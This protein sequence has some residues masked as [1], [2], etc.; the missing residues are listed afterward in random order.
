MWLHNPDWKVLPTIYFVDGYPH[1]LTCKYHD[2]GCNL[3][4]IHCC[5][6]RTNIPSPLSD[7]VFRAIGK[8]LTVKHMKVGYNFT[9]Y[10]MA[11]QRSSRKG[12]DTINVSSVGNTD[13]GYILIQEYKARSYANRAD[14]KGIIQGIIDDEKYPTIMLKEYKSFLKKSRNFDYMKYKFGSNYVPAEITMSMK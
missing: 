11:E 7:Q 3:I 13:H 5:I 8:P 4:Q 6:W 2:G 9:G 14:M 1:V 10:Q 12:P